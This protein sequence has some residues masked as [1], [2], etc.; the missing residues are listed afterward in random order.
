VPLIALCARG[1]RTGPWRRLA[2]AAW[3]LATLWLAGVFDA[4]AQAPQPV[5]ELTARV[6]DLTGTLSDSARTALE[7]KLAALERERG[8]QVVFLMVR[9]TQP[10]DIFSYANRV[11]STW[12]IGRQGVGDGV[13]LVVALDDRRVR[14]EVARTLEGAIPD[15]AAS[16]I[17]EEVITPAFRQGDFAGGLDA[18]ADHLASRIRGEALPLPSQQRQGGRAGG[19]PGFNFLDLAIL[20]F[21]AVPI[22]GGILRRILGRPLGAVVT[23]GGVG[24]LALLFT[25]SIVVA[26]LA[27]LVGLFFALIGGMGP[28]PGTGGMRGRRGGWG[29]PHGG[30]WGAP[31]GGGFGGGGFRSGGGGSFGGGGASGGW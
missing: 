15:L 9:T 29:M 23:G 10:E 31:R 8:A 5:P 17:I 3:L 22:A 18:G 30:G 20:L 7:D 13:L 26:V 16:R 4:A 12:K 25:S 27:G 1:A 28:P 14:I 2:W 6:M 11:G 19:A 24:L 21:F